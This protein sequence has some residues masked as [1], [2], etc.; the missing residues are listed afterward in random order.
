MPTFNA[1][2]KG[3]M[4]IEF[5]GERFLAGSSFL[6]TTAN[7]IGESKLQSILGHG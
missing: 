4:K 6:A 2:V 7:Y 1:A 5:V 3:A